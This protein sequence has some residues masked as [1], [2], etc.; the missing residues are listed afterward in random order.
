MRIWIMYK[1]LNM[2]GSS[3][4]C[5]CVLNGTNCCVVFSHVLC[6]IFVCVYVLFVAWFWCACE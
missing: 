1:L 3:I 6:M 4:S 2:S 5:V